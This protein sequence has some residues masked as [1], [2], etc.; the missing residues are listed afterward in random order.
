MRL[1]SFHVGAAPSFGILNEDGSVLD[2]G[3]RYRADFQTLRSAIAA[4]LF[5]RELPSDLVCHGPGSFQLA[6]PI[7]DAGKI[8]CVGRNYRGHVA[9]AGLKLPDYPNLF[10]RFADSLVPPEAP[11][12]KPSVSEQFDFEGE[13][14]IVIARTARHVP[15]RDAMKY[16]LG[17]TC[18]NDGSIRDFQLQQSLT[19]GKNFRATGSFG[20]AILTM[21]E[22]AD[23]G[24]MEIETRLNGRMVQHAR[25]SELIFDIPFLI[26]YVSRFTLLRPG[27]ILATGTPD[28]VGLARSPQLWMKAGDVVEV[29]VPG[30]GTLRNPVSAEATTSAD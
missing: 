6:L 14:A 13:V 4:R 30:V 16:V 21:D 17:L 2:L 12:V 22:V 24:A 3:A 10:V 7:P 15:A 19:A 28:G 11:L 1:A 20:P 26:E 8:I 27:D 23:L 18:F 9:E 29:T 5:D 25:L